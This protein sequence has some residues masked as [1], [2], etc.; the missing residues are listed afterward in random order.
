M[1]Q[2]TECGKMASL[3][4][5]MNAKRIILNGKTRLEDVMIK[6]MIHVANSMGDSREKAF[7]AIEHY[8]EVRFSFYT[9]CKECG[10]EVEKTDNYCSTCGTKI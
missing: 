8:K 9:R 5:A 2:E 3:A 7:H 10:C 6:H 1:G 4:D